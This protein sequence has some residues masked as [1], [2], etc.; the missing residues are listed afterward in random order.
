MPLT[1]KQRKEFNELRAKLREPDFPSLEECQ[2][3]LNERNSKN[4]FYWVYNLKEDRVVLRKGIEKYLGYPPDF[5]L[6]LEIMSTRIPENR[7]NLYNA[8]VIAAYK[9][10]VEYEPKEN[11]HKGLIYFE[12]NKILLDRNDNELYTYQ[13]VEPLQFDSN[14][15]MVS[16]LSW[17]HIKEGY[18]NSREFQGGRFVTDSRI[19]RLELLDKLKASNNIEQ[20][21]NLQESQSKLVKYKIELI[22]G[23]PFT[24]QE[25]LIISKLAVYIGHNLSEDQKNREVA[26]LLKINPNT[27]TK[28][29]HRNHIKRKAR[30]FFGMNFPS[31]NDLLLFL[32]NENLILF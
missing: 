12:G 7:R 9:V 14:G 31:F 17:Y 18:K 25:Q 4:S 32:E 1:T 29:N 16:N 6:G 13:C 5:E 22:E 19:K 3:I 21:K 23:F 27:T 20:I 24:H 8:Q 26:E 30:E 10:A 28:R 15:N 2:K 11:L